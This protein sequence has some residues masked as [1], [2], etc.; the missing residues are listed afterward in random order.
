[1]TCYRLR[2]L[3]SRDYSILVDFI[4]QLELQEVGK[5]VMPYTNLTRVLRENVSAHVLKGAA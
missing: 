5:I 3:S 1:M 4:R 2:N